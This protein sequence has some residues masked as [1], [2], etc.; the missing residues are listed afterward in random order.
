[1]GLRSLVA[2]LLVA[3]GLMWAVMFFAPLAYL[4]HLAGVLT[5]AFRP[6]TRRVVLIDEG[7][8]VRISSMS[9]AVCLILISWHDL[10]K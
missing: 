2:V 8:M 3:S 9:V 5:D 10:T 6:K 1:L 7:V 4:T